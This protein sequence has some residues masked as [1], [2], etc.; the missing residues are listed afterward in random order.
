LS[1]ADERILRALASGETHQ[2]AID[3]VALQ[4]LKQ[5]GLVED[6]STGPKITEKGRQAMATGR[7]HGH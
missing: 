1:N 7:G 2:I 6:T 4:H 5:K 3:W